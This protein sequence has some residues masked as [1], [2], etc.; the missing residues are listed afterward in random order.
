M[1]AEYGYGVKP[2]TTGD[3]YSF[4][5]LVLELFTCR[6]PTHE[7]FG[8]GVTLKSW[9]QQYFPT[10]VEKVI[11]PGLIEEMSNFCEDIIGNNPQ[12]LSQSQRQRDCLVTVVEVGLSCAAESPDARITIRDALRKLTKAE[13]MLLKQEVAN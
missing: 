13:D 1:C 12:C 3:V 4:G 6:S 11:E 10:N 7:M 5:I 8:G 2:S 9:V